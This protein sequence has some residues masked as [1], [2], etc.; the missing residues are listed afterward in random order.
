MRG[1]DVTPAFSGRRCLLLDD[2]K[3]QL[4]FFENQLK[5]LG[6]EAVPCVRA[7]EVLSYLEH[8]PFDVVFT[9]MQMPEMDGL[10]FLK[11]LRASEFAQARA[12]PVVVV[13]ARSDADRLLSEGFSSILHKPFRWPNSPTV[14]RLFGRR[15]P[16]R[17]SGSR[18]SPGLITRRE[19]MTSRR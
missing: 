1:R 14:C 16:G 15:R 10:Q 18:C 11:S 8:E 3:L 5:Q 7:E 19:G 17:L 9:D 2:D 6:V 12:I 13:T 4:T